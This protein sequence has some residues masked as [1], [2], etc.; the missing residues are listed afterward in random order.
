MN[1]E[2]MKFTK[3]GPYPPIEITGHNPAYARE[4]LDNLGGSNSEI[5]AVS[6]YF[7]NNL[8]TQEKYEDIAYIFHKISIVEMHHLEIFGKMA[9]CL[10]EDPRL[11]TWRYNRRNYW[12]PAYNRY[13]SEFC[14]LIYNA[15]NGELAAIEKYECQVRCIDNKNIVE[16]LCRII[17]DEKVH[18]DIFRQIIEEYHL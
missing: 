2:N 17:E 8:M 18:V 3:D 11:W 5:S 6:L 12:T 7:Y 15:L 1:K 16:N 13:P 9:Y 14:R 4:M 10:G